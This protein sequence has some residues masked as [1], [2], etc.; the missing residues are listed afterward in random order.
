MLSKSLP[1]LRLLASTHKNNLFTGSQINFTR[2]SRNFS[3]FRLQNP[4]SSHFYITRRFKS[5]VPTVSACNHDA[6]SPNTS[7][8][9]DNKITLNSEKKTP[10]DGKMF[11]AFT[12][13]VCSTRSQKYMSKTAYT[14]GVVLIQCSGCKNRHLIADNLGWFGEGN[15]IIDIL[16]KKGISEKVLTDDGNG[17]I[18]IVDTATN[19]KN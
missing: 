14:K 11:I 16:K 7:T 17:D 9:T 2:F 5:I 6:S 10:Q 12:C 19:G 1:F 13:K 8:K 3:T 4:N 15:N 18:E